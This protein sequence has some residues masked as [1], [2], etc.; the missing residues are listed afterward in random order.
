MQIMETIAKV[1]AFRTLP[2]TVLV[3]VVYAGL[4]GAV[5][6]GNQ[7]AE[8]PKN[9]NGLDLA[10]AY[11]DLHHIAGRPHPFLSHENDKVHS[12][13][14]ERMRKVTSG[15]DF[16]EVYDDLVSNASWV[17]SSTAPVIYNEATNILVKI[18]GS[19]TEYTSSGVLFSAHFDSVSTASGATDDGMGVATLMQL[20]EYLAKN[21]P[22][23]TAVFNINNGEEDGLCGAYTFL[24]HPWSNLT[25]TFLNLEGAAAGGRPLLFR[26]T[27]TP[28]L[29]S[30]HVAHPHGNVLSADG[31]ARG[32]VRSGTDYTVY[33]GI[34]MEGLDLAFYKGRSKY[35]TKYDAIPHT[36]GQEKALWAMM[37]SA[38]DSG[39]SL[40]E[41]DKTHGSGTPPV[42]FDLFGV[43]LVLFPLDSLFVCNIVLLIVGPLV[44][45]LLVVADAAIL[46]GRSQNQN[47]HVPSD[48]L[49]K[50]FWAW[51]IEFG[52]IKGAWRWAKFWVAV[53]VTAGFQ[54]LLVFAYMKLNPLIVYSQ[55]DLV[56][57]SSFTLTYL[58][59]VFVVTPSSNH[60]PEKQK[61]IMFLQTYILTWIL[62][63]GS[64][65]AVS[66]GIGGVYF[67]TAWNATVL[68]ACAIGCVENMFGARG[69]YEL[70][71]RFVRRARY[72]ALP[73]RDEEH[74]SPPAEATRGATEAT[75]LIQ[76]STPRTKEESGAIGW[77]ILQ[78]ILAISVP[79][80]LV[81]HITVLLTAAMTQTLADGSSALTVY[82]V[83]SILV[84]MMV[85]PV[86][87]F[88]FKIHSAVASLFIIVFILSTGYNLLA[89]PFSQEEPLKVFFIQKVALGNI[90]S[91]HTEIAHATTTLTGLPYYMKDLILP[92][93]PSTIGQNIV[94]ADL[95]LRVGLQTCGWESTLLPSPGAYLG[96]AA[97]VGADHW[98]KAN[99]TRLGPNSARFVV[100]A[101]NSRGCKLNFDNKRIKSHHVHGSEPGM[102]TPFSGGSEGISQLILYSRTWD[103]T[104]TVD[105]DWEGD[106][107][108]E[109]RI[110]CEWAEYE[111]GSVG[112]D[113]TGKIPA[114]EEVLTFLPRWTAVTKQADGLVEAWASFSI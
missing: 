29:R 113:T 102:L 79:V 100:A 109:G 53:L 54:A 61:H 30:F 60:L 14:L 31:F 26:A 80:T 81:A 18:E 19:D 74:P 93:I 84:F 35:H 45:I 42:Y 110:A 27:S 4:F 3:L 6:F 66:S 17:S 77:W 21:R 46:H 86:V 67:I 103:R 15:I 11:A 55:A 56:L 71:H 52:W 25:D 106:A 23:R 57:T 39:L 51:L 98:L 68:L 75:P 48:N 91:P 101:A 88:T 69:S 72:D 111:S 65:I 37:E 28:A 104:F 70:P 83:V 108:L 43:W 85:L 9:Q 5:L 95:P 34:G 76:S 24:K 82:I 87:P 1:L 90:S 59:L 36:L 89:F 32:V 107:V 99:V 64:T 7:V 63:V 16:I 47:G 62:L 41:N 49:L 112:V 78:L 13:I 12:Y 44:L 8:V 33:T 10:Q 50:Q 94:C 114:L 96:S 22:K 40:L 20:V 105:I 38:K 2:T 58:T 73:Q 97:S 92:K